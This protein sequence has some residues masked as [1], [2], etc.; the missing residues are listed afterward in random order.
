MSCIDQRTYLPNSSS[1]KPA[2]SRA[3]SEVSRASNTSRVSFEST[4]EWR[5]SFLLWDWLNEH[6]LKGMFFSFL[7]RLF[8]Y[9][10]G[11]SLP[12]VSGRATHGSTLNPPHPAIYAV[13]QLARTSSSHVVLGIPSPGVDSH[14]KGSRWV[15]CSLIQQLYQENIL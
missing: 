11:S 5:W 9:E 12:R 13:H 3:E 2:R 10:A 15:W 4:W 14:T 8:R 7:F 1:L 6:P